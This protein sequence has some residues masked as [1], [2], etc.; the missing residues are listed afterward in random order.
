MA[1]LDE[2]DIIEDDSFRTVFS[3]SPEVQEAIDQVLDK[4]VQNI[5][6]VGVALR[7]SAVSDTPGAKRYTTPTAPTA[8]AA[9]YCINANLN[10]SANVCPSV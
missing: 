1:N 7:W 4:C 2:E 3:F 5:V 10:L 8:W 9:N 6:E